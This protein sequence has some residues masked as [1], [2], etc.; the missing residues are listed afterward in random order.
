MHRD[1]T[2]GSR[3]NPGDKDQW[4]YIAMALTRSDVS[5]KTW[6]AAQCSSHHAELLRREVSQLCHLSATVMHSCYPHKS[7]MIMYYDALK[8]ISH[9]K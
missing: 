4:A 3:D 2:G 9:P 5:H 7:H 6:T 8:L 1:A